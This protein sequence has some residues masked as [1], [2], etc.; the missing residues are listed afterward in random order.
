[1]SFPLLQ[2]A[3]SEWSDWVSFTVVKKTIA[4]FEVV[5]T[6]YQEEIFNGVLQPLSPRKLSVKPEGQRD[7]KW[8]TLWT[9]KILPE[10]AIIQGSDGRYYRVMSQTDWRQAG[11]VEYQLVESP[12]PPEQQPSTVLP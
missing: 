11:Y 7:W 9:E 10:D 4:N 3:F 5:E 8:L 6:Q 1:M 12:Q 2:E